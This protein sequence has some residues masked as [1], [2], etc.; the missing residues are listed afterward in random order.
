MKFFNF[1]LVAQS[2]TSFCATRFRNSILQ[3]KN[4]EP[5]IFQGVPQESILRL[6]LFNLFLWDFLFVVEGDFMS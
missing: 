2:V 5:H 6:P 3:L 1:E 4:S